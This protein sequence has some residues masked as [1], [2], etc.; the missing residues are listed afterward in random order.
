MLAPNSS[1]SYNGRPSFVNPK[2][3]KKAQSE[4]P[5]LYHVPY[6]KQDLANIFAPNCDET[7]LLEQES[8]SKLDK[9][10]IKKYDYTYQNSLYELFTPQTHKSLDQLYFSNEIRMKMWR[11]SFVKY[12][13]N[14]V[15]NIGFLLAQA[16]FSKSRHAFNLVLHNITNFK[17]IVD[18]DWQKGL[19]NRWQQPITHEINMLVQNLLMPLVAKTKANANEFKRALKEEMFDDLQYVQSL[20]KKVDKLEYEKA[21]FSNEYD[22]LLQEYVSKDIMWAILRS[23]DNIDEQT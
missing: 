13:P 4:N 14:I 20:E 17:T 2:Y 23:F 1:L 19:D 5:C 16:S 11:K 18:M 9:E 15:K 6:D 7:L 21:E 3:L 10:L 22:L 8:R 12:K